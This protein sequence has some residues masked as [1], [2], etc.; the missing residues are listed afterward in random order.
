MKNGRNQR[1]HFDGSYRVQFV[2]K[3]CPSTA[4]V[5]WHLTSELLDFFNGPCS[6]SGASFLVG[7]QLYDHYLRGLVSNTTPPQHS[8]KKLMEDSES[9]QSDPVGKIEM[10]S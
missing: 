5:C 3:N 4:Q 2:G 9:P 10:P 7:G 1:E 6:G 8:H